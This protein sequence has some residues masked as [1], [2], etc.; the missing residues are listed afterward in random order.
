M[1]FVR[2][3]D[4]DRAL[5]DED[6]VGL[7]EVFPYRAHVYWKHVVFAARPVGCFVLEA[8]VHL[9]VGVQ[10]LGAHVDPEVIAS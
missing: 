1:D 9:E 7:P 10:A 4:A 3:D 2:S 5:D 6:V 8:Y